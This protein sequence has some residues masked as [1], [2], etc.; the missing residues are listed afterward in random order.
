MGRKIK[1]VWK[2]SGGMSGERI[3]SWK[4]LSGIFLLF[5]FL[6]LLPALPSASAATYRVTVGGAGDKSGSSWANAMSGATFREKLASSSPEGEYWVTRGIYRPT[7]NPYDRSASFILKRGVAL[8]GGFAGKEKER[9]ERNPAANK[10]VLSG[11]IG[12]GAEERSFYVVRSRGADAAAVIDGF[13]IAD[14]CADHSNVP[15]LEHGSGMYNENSSPTVSNCTFSGNSAGTGG[16]MHNES[17]SPVVTNCTF[18]KNAAKE[19]GGGMFNYDSSPTVTNCTFYE[20]GAGMGGGMCNESSSPIVINCTFYENDARWSGGGMVNDDSSPIVVNCTFLG[21]TMGADNDGMFNTGGSSPIITNC[22]F[23][24]SENQTLIVGSDSSPTFSWCVVQGGLIGGKNIIDADPKLGPL[25]D[26]GGPT[27]TCAPGKG[28]SAI[29]GGTAEGAPP[30]D[31]RG[32]SRPQ[33]G[34]IDIGAVEI[35]PR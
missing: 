33:G 10:T 18:Y 26:N 6:L 24:G 7:S 19:A 12:A 3:S 17:S 22:I 23:W 2:G 16:G 5:I 8:Y 28:S 1:T 21:N 31:Q 29:D 15:N 25:A 34:G 32:V 14:A 9:K 11:I 35:S 13:T 27:K 30:T 4:L 20:N